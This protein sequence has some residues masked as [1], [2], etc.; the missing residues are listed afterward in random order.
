METLAFPN[1]S[2]DRMF[3]KDL[4]DRNTQYVTEI[5]MFLEVVKK[6]VRIEK[7]YYEEMSQLIPTELMNKDCLIR[8]MVLPLLDG[9]QRKVNEKEEYLNTV[10]SQEF[11]ELNENVILA[12][13]EIIHLRKKSTQYISELY[14]IENKIM[15]DQ[16]DYWRVSREME[17]AI[18]NFVCLGAQ[19]NKRDRRQA[20]RIMADK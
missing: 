4:Q 17:I 19:A 12:E 15:K 11:I 2:K 3:Y 18:H 7:K 5:R 20:Q 6:R 10:N 1:I 9:I 13:N 8:C 14:K 16:K